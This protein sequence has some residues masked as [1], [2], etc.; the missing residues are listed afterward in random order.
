L[1]RLQRQYFLD[2]K[3]SALIENRFEQQS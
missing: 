1:D 3:S 2:L